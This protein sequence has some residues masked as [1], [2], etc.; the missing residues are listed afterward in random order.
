MSN[1]IE[2]VSNISIE[3]FH[4]EVVPNGKPLVIRGL[5]SD[6]PIVQAGKAGATEFCN[7]IKR[8]DRGYEVN[9]V[10]GPPS[11]KGRI[12][13]NRDMSGLNCKMGQAKIST[14]LD[15]LLEH[16]DDN[17]SPTL[18]M[19][20]VVIPSFLSGIQQENILKLLSPF[21]EPRIWIG[22]RVTVAAHYDPSENIACC[23]AG[24]R[25]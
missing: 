7:Y 2:E 13:Y 5:V 16:I 9:T 6:W 21:V 8:F 3:E 19:Q 1:K 23:L 14:S 10:Y 4:N 20:S 24:R 15:Y 22:G 18:A 11:I 25:R 17:P 12:F